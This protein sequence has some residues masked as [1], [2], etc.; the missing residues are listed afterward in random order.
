MKTGFNVN[1]TFH[2]LNFFLFFFH[3]VVFKNFY[4]FIF[5]CSFYLQH[6]HPNM[7]AREHRSLEQRGEV[8]RGPHTREG[9]CPGPEAVMLKEKQKTKPH[10]PRSPDTGRA[11]QVCMGSTLQDEKKNQKITQRECRK[12]RGEVRLWGWVSIDE[13][14]LWQLPP[15]ARAVLFYANCKLR[16]SVFGVGWLGRAAAAAWWCM[17]CLGSR[18]AWERVVTVASGLLES[19]A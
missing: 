4:L 2:L 3:L 11:G 7:R 14:C 13:R 16:V 17:R 12:G 9:F 8:E 5:F 10:N 19:L 1:T 15:P 6:K 18:Q